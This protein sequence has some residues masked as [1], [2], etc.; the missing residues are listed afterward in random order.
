MRESLEKGPPIH[1]HSTAGHPFSLLTQQA[2]PRDETKNHIC[3]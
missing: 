2:F 1:P 3:A